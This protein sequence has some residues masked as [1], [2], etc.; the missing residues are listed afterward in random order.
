[1]EN[2]NDDKTKVKYITK[3]DQQPFEGRY[4]VGLSI[5]EEQNFQIKSCD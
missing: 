5:I 3:E 4:L 1:M 2:K